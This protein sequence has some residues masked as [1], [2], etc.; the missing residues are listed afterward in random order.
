MASHGMSDPEELLSLLALP[1]CQTDQTPGA[2]ER[3]L[4]E[5]SVQCHQY[6]SW[7]QTAVSRLQDL[8]WTRGGPNRRA[9]LARD[10]KPELQMTLFPRWQ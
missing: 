6:P 9:G 5:R 3:L 8:W 7:R 10:P 4:R 2:P 1:A